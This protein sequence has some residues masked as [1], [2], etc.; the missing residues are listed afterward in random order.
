MDKGIECFYGADVKKILVDSVNDKLYA[1]GNFN[2]DG[3]CVPMRGM[4]MWDGQHWDSIGNG[5]EGIAMKYMMALYNNDLYAYG[6]FYNNNVDEY[7]AKW[8]GVSWDTISKNPNG[9]IACTVQRDGV[10]Y[11][12]GFFSYLGHDSTFLLGSYDGSQFHALTPAYGYPGGWAIFAMAFFQDTLYVGGNFNTLPYKNL[13]DFAK[14]D[15]TDLQVVHPDFANNGA[16]SMIEAM[17]VYHGELYIGGYFRKINGYTGDY[18]MKWDGHNFSEVGNGMNER[19]TT[20]KVYNDQLYVGGCF[21]QAGSINS[22]YIARWDGVNW[23]SITADSFT[24]SYP[25]IR[26]L[27]FYR[28]TLIISGT[29]KAINGDTNMYRIAKY[30]HP[31]VGIQSL[32][33]QNEF[34]LYPNPTQSTLT[35]QLS[36]AIKKNLTIQIKNTLGQTI[37]TLQLSPGNKDLEIDVSDLSEGLY[38]V[39]YRS[40]ETNVTKKFI[41]Q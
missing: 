10:L 6:N 37:K 21:T 16:L 19:V 4:A 1:N 34:A 9:T 14:W 38:F 12:G 23:Y 24:G 26:D 29:F 22:N 25:M 18:I 15:G 35:L 28:D 33:M 32:F 5:T 27:N 40:G 41:K 13:A 36:E 7:F 20:M 2:Q 8:N 30:S 17:V 31:L 11:L 3:N 39:Q